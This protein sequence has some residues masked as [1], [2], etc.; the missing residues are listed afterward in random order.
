MLIVAVNEN[1]LLHAPKLRVE[2]LNAIAN[3]Y[4]D[5]EFSQGVCNRRMLA[6]N[7]YETAMTGEGRRVAQV[8]KDFEAVAELCEEELWKHLREVFWYFWGGASVFEAYPDA[9]EELASFK[10]KRG[11][12]EHILNSRGYSVGDAARRYREIADMIT[13]AKMR[14][15]N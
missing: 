12:L 3:E 8:M 6:N 11:E 14:N 7:A 9:Q 2:A 13:N 4:L 5:F 10:Q 1:E 15:K